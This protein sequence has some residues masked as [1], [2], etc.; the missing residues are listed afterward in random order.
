M[1]SDLTSH[2][3]GTLLVLVVFIVTYPAF[4]QRLLLKD[5]TTADGLPDSRVAP[6]IQDSKGYLW[7]GTQA[8]LTRY[9]GKEFR[10][11]GGA[12]EIPGIF[13]RDIAED[14]R[15][16]IWFAYTGFN[17]GGLLR[18]W[19]GAITNF[20]H[21]EGLPGDEAGCVV[22]DAEHTIWAGS[23]RGLSRIRFTDSART[24][25]TVDVYPDIPAAALFVDSRKRLWIGTGNGDLYSYSHGRFRLK[26]RMGYVRPYAIYESRNGELWVGGISGAVV[27]TPNGVEQFGPHDGLPE[28]GVWSFIEDNQGNFWVGTVEGLYRMHRTPSSTRFAKERS[29]GDALVYDMCLDAE[30]NTWFASDPGLRKLLA[31]DLVVD[32]PGRTGLAT[33]GFGPI[34]QQPD[35][36]ILFGS[37]NLGVFALKG[38]LLLYGKA[39]NPRTT[40]T[41][42]DIFPESPERTWFGMKHQA[43][44]LQDGNVTHQFKDYGQTSALSIHCIERLPSDEILLGS[45]EGLKR[46][47]GGDSLLPMH[48]PDLDSLVIFDMARQSLKTSKEQADDTLWLA[49]DRGLRIVGIE[50]TAIKHARRVSELRLDETIVYVLLMDRQNRLVC[51]TDGQGV[52]VYDGARFT[53]YTRD[54]GLVGDRVYALAQDSLGQIWIGTSSGLSCFDGQSFRNFRHEQGLSEIG[55]HGLMTDRDGNL[56]ASSFPGISKLRPQ[57]FF[58]ST[59]PPPIYILDMQVDTLHLGAAPDIQ[60]DPDPAVIT[61]R[62]AGLSFTDEANVRYKYRLDGFDRDWSVPVTQREVRY[63]HLGSGRYTFQVI[64]RS[65]DG[66][67]SD[68]PAMISFSILPPLWARWWFITGGLVIIIGAVYGLY[69]Y[70]LEKALQLERTRSRIAMDL[71]DDIG[72]SLTRIS[73]LSEVARRQIDGDALARAETL[74]RIGES[75]RELIESL[76][77][78]V[79][80]VDPKHDALQN[81]I[82]RIVEFGQ[83]VCE[84]KGIVFE[85]DIQATFDQTTLSLEQRRDVYLVFKEAINNMVRH[86]QATRVRFSVRE[87]ES[88]AILELV[89]DGV[90]YQAESESAGH[91][92]V[93]MQ[94]RARRAGAMLTTDS[95][96]GHGTRTTMRIRTG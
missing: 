70:R 72:S 46:L 54:D 17:R 26:F 61:F 51:G 92:L 91:G 55:L 95:K 19:N 34:A 83:D 27:V 58:K 63:T 67:W 76:G 56:W 25:W 14:H 69:R 44:L 47:G 13:G 96:P 9:D 50:G 35:G 65:A 80:S 36:T 12:K 1:R 5:Y 43:L 8:G 24:R 68:S 21:A 10:W 37:R 42:L 94:E 79:W 85:T 18:Y 22:E 40:F 7:F 20:G 31:A 41:V 75:A 2:N 52:V 73:V 6:I 15:G 11:F 62:Y 82:R 60:L 78:I 59:R 16:A 77:D 23:S 38:T 81:V 84:G 29:F 32:F 87:L 86:S 53:R 88:T 33:P 30:G 74:A 66:V 89:D 71:H 4:A 57:R 49:T 93:T 39:V 90:G 28:R 64:A 3:G 48:H 45:N